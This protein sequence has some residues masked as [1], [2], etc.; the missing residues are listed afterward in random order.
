LV[1]KAIVLYRFAGIDVAVG[2]CLKR[3]CCTSGVSEASNR[4]KG[5]QTQT[6]LEHSDLFSIDDAVYDRTEECA[7]HESCRVTGKKLQ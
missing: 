3:Y 6:L 5:C 2:E 4:A 1:A 7:N